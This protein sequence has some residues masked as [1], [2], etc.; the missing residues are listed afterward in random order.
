MEEEYIN[1]DDLIKEANELYSK[2]NKEE[3]NEANLEYFETINRYINKYKIFRKK[4]IEIYIND[5]TTILK[6]KNIKN[7]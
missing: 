6:Q 5:L 4:I 2:I 7:I 1:C 3:L